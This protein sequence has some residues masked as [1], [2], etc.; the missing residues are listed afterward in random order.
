M[1]AESI[2]TPAEEVRVNT[3]ARNSRFVAALSHT[4]DVDAARNFIQRIKREFPDANHH[5]AAYVIGGGNSVMEYCTDDGEPSGT[6]GRPVL[7][8]LRTSG[9]G[10]AALVVTRFF[11]G[12]LL[13]KGGLVKAYTEAAQLAVHNVRRARKQIMSVLTL[14]IPYN[15]L[16]QTRDKVKSIN[17]HVVNEN[18][19]ESVDMTVQ[20]PDMESPGFRNYIRDL[21][22]GKCVPRTEEMVEVL[23]P[24]RK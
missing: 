21:T 3:T 22:S 9:L 15:K 5:V 11:G 20:I 16:E 6:A 24:V 10:N 8:V 4:A 2:E 19:A 13:G 12:T 17:G 1:D 23:V 7:T 18:F 14:E